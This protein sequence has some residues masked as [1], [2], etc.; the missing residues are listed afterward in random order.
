MDG[1]RAVPPGTSGASLTPARA[2]T[3]PAPSASLR[4][5]AAPRQPGPSRNVHCS[6]MTPLVPP[7][8]S[9][10]PNIVSTAMPS[11][12]STSR[13]RPARTTPPSRSIDRRPD[14]S[15]S[16]SPSAPVSIRFVAESSSSQVPTS[17]GHERT[18]RMSRR[19]HGAQ[20]RSRGETRRI[21]G[22]YVLRGE[23]TVTSRQAQPDAGSRA[24][25]IV[26]ATELEIAGRRGGREE[27][28]AGIADI[29]RSR[30][31]REPA[32]GGPFRGARPRGNGS[33]ETGQ[34][35][36][37]PRGPLQRQPRP[38]SVARHGTTPR[39]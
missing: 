7:V 23:S 12:R 32:R 21:D 1:R 6:S 34:T 10:V 38:E 17:V 8:T 27:I 33:R 26:P 3:S 2:V 15:S 24:A 37:D 36:A 25:G 31:D 14:G 9:P 20:E 16:R 35:E 4:V 11:S 39:P 13:A 19:L 30:A 18:S 5:P 28:D 22:T 29:E